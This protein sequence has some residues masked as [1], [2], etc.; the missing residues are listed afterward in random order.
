MNHP[1]VKY[2]N[3]NPAH[4]PWAYVF[5]GLVCYFAF[6]Y[7]K[8]KKIESNPITKDSFK[9]R[10]YSIMVDFRDAKGASDFI[11]EIEDKFFREVPATLFNFYKDQN[12]SV[13][14]FD[15]HLAHYM[16]KAIHLSK[17]RYPEFYQKSDD[18]REIASFPKNKSGQWLLKYIKRRIRKNAVN[19]DSDA[20]VF[21]EMLTRN[22]KVH[23]DLLPHYFQ[24][25][26]RPDMIH[27]RKIDFNKGTIDSLI[28]RLEN[29]TTEIAARTSKKERASLIEKQSPSEA[30][31]ELED[32][33]K[34]VVIKDSYNQKR[35]DVEA[36]LMGHCAT[37]EW[38]NSF[39]IS[40]RDKRG[41]PWV[42]ATIKKIADD[43]IILGQVKGRGNKKPSAKFNEQIYSLFALP[44]IIAQSSDDRNDWRVD[45]FSKTQIDTLKDDKPYFF[46][47]KKLN[48]YFPTKKLIAIIKDRLNDY[49]DITIHN[50]GDIYYHV[51]EIKEVIRSFF[52]HYDRNKQKRVYD[53]WVKIL[54]DQH[55]DIDF[56]VTN[57]EAAEWFIDNF[58]S[59]KEGQLIYKALGK[60]L[61]KDDVGFKDKDDY[62]DNLRW[63]FHYG[64]LGDELYA[65]INQAIL[66]SY[67]NSLLNQLE[68]YLRWFFEEINNELPDH[69]TV[70][71][72]DLNDNE[73]KLDDIYY[74]SDY[75]IY[76]KSSVNNLLTEIAYDHISPESL[77]DP[78][79]NTINY[80]KDSYWKNVVLDD[81]SS[82]YA[83]EIFKETHLSEILE[84][85]KNILKT[86]K[87]E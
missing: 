76:L 69:I 64:G 8:Q 29:V 10:Y 40:L 20:D 42:T 2:S 60:E 11:D 66:D 44:E 35:D 16:A 73:I 77:S 9:K 7:N 30:F 12:I 61:E 52:S 72:S 80:L 34:W 75:Q 59:T 86:N 68:E 47:S 22:L 15:I 79:E 13:P 43:M 21:W 65:A 23:I 67:S 45:D 81:Y 24:M 82:E 87:D 57:E 85:S 17:S 5:S 4:R 37:P 53:W 1:M 41:E 46:D 38:E 51:G 50:D 3:I 74:Q 70:E 28:G 54:E 18:G 32:G 56:S 26:D 36:A 83:P 48:E 71:F 84:K 62:K 58:L 33:W 25:L 14:Y 27:A 78:F 39:L 19:F 49:G 6:F 55:I 31:I 63:S